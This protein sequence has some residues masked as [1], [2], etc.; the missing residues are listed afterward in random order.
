MLARVQFLPLAVVFPAAILAHEL[1]YPVLAGGLKALGTAARATWRRH[2]LLAGLYGAVLLAALVATLLTS[3]SGALGVYSPTLSQGSLL[4]GGMAQS[5][6]ADLD[7]V[8]IGCGLLPLV[9]GGGWMLTAAFRPPCE[10]KHALAVLSLLTIVVLTLETAS[11]DLRFGG[12]DVI[13]DRYVFYIVPPL[14][15]GTAALLRERRTPWL[16]P[17]ALAAL[18]AG[19]VHWLPLPPVKGVWVDSPTRVLNDLIVDASGGLSPAAFVATAGCLI[20]LCALL[21][22]RIVPRRALAPSIFA[23]LLAFSV[24]ATQRVIDHTLASNSVSSRAMSKPAGIVLDWVDRVLPP[25][26]PR[27]SSRTRPPPAS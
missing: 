15:V 21:A 1:G 7:S 6:A 10:R 17:A 4:P 11:F 16:A 19:T 9:L 13:R 23:A 18:F 14:L 8:A 2:R 25:E 20:T 27:R 3:I 5:A 12:R 22:L 24:F 26:P